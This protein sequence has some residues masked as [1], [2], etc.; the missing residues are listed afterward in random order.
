MPKINVVLHTKIKKEVGRDRLTIE[1]STGKEALKALASELGAA[2]TN[3]I[4][5]AKGK[6]KSH[7]IFI[8]NGVMLSQSELNKTKFKADDIFQIYMPIGGG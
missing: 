7:Y 1:A 5:D 4:F 8:L 3:E 2:F 6:I